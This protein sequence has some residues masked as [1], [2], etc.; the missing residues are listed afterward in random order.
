[1]VGSDSFERLFLS[2]LR[3]EP[4]APAYDFALAIRQLTKH[5][6]KD[7]TQFLALEHFL[8][9]RQ[10]IDEQ[11]QLQNQLLNLRDEPAITPDGT[12][13][14]LLT[15]TGLLADLSPG[16]RNGAQG[17]GLYR[18]EIPFMVRNSFPSEQDQEDVYRQVF[19]AYAGRPVYM[20]TLDVGGDKQLPYFPIADEENPE[21]GWRGMLIAAPTFA[22]FT[23]PLISP[24]ISFA[25]F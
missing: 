12:S 24:C 23:Y 11:D 22:H 19:T 21:L 18:T 14:R 16:L 8:R 4:K 1:M 7:R 9:R 25:A 20:R 15:N 6:L 13:I 5:V 3:L 17:I 10:L 2:A